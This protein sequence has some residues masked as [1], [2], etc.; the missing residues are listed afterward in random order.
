MDLA[1]FIADAEPLTG[2]V[3]LLRRCPSDAERKLLILAAHDHGA[4]VADEAMLLIS[5]LL[6]EAA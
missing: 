5:A 3:D 2:F 1:P 4:L 6:L